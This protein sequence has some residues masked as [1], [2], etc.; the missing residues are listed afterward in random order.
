LNSA[1]S[2]HH[3]ALSPS[4]SAFRTHHSAFSPSHSAFRTHHSA[5]SPS[6]SALRTHH[7][8]LI[9]ILLFVLLSLA[10]AAKKCPK[11]GRTYEDAENY[12][13]ECTGENGGPVK[14]NPAAPPAPKPKPKIEQPSTPAP[15]IEQP[16]TGGV[17]SLG[18]NAQG[19]EEIL[20][21]KDSSVM[22]R[23]PAGTFTMGSSDGDADEKPVHQ[24]SLDEY[25]I[26]K[27]EVTNR[28]Y[29]R[30]C[31]ATGKSYPSDPGFSGMSSY[32]TSYPDYPVVKVSWDDAAAYCTWAGKRL[33]TEAEWEK[34]ARG[35]DSR[36]Y[37]W[38]NSEPDAGGFYRA[39][40]GEGTD[41]SVWKR[42]GYEY[43]S[44]V[45]SYERGASP[46]GCMDMA[47]NVWE[48]CAD[49]YD[50]SYYS[51]SPSSSPAGPSSGSSRVLRGGSWYFF[52]GSLRCADRGGDDPS[53]RSVYYGF[54]CC[55]VVR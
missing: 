8:A 10:L 25:Y 14:L 44:P 36:K 49:W 42:D 20:W 37:P 19:Y 18:R 4:H 55:S 13:S 45:G 53:Y 39:N 26:D 46:Y 35:N 24:V 31:D 50:G 17:R 51:R 5:F 21:P 52:A 33:P 28:Q 2:N 7:S 38:G 15:K 47:G 16:S 22:I 27:Y 11:C 34:A 41:R 3:S 12:C 9:L 43:T 6:H 1:L 54:R 40:W 48:W 32:F 29:K 23:I 30:F